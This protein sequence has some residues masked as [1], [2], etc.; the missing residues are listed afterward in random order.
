[1]SP[2]VSAFDAS[3]DGENITYSPDQK[4]ILELDVH[5]D[6]GYS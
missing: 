3:L 5:F 4:F 1:M 2:N 6:G